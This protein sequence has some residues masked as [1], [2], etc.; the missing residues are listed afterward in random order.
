M[1]D[2]SLRTD[3]ILFNANFIATIVGHDRDYILGETLDD[4]ILMLRRYIRELS[5]YFTVSEEQSKKFNEILDFDETVGTYHS[6][7]GRL[8][9]CVNTLGEYSTSTSRVRTSA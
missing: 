7:L 1:F 9:W 8:E 3:T 6:H 2:Y 5:T 4:E